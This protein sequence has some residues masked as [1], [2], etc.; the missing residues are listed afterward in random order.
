MEEGA[1]HGREQKNQKGSMG[2]WGN[3]RGDASIMQ[4]KARSRIEDQASSIKGE[5]TSAAD[6]VAHDDL[7]STR[8][9]AGGGRLEARGQRLESHSPITDVHRRLLGSNV[10]MLQ[11]GQRTWRVTRLR[12]YLCA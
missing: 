12:L 2:P 6:L 10:L 9:S 8:C 3:G 7:P 4:F 1:G 11:Y 5:V